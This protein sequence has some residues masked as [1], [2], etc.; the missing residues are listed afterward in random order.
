M[1]ICPLITQSIVIDKK[2][3]LIREADSTDLDG[4]EGETAP[5]GDGEEDGEDSE[6]IS[7]DYE[8]GADGAASP[9]KEESS[10]E[11]P[12]T[13]QDDRMVRF[14]AKSYRGEV[15]C[16]AE[17]CRFYDDDRRTCRLEAI[18]SCDTSSA[19][20]ENEELQSIRMDVE[21]IWEFQQKST[22]EILGLFKELEEKN[23]KLLEGLE[24]TFDDK[25]KSI[26]KDMTAAIEDGRSAVKSVAETI[27]DEIENKISSGEEKIE[28][29]RKE[30]TDW[31][32]VL[33]K[34]FESLESELESHKK[35]VDELSG[36]H[37]EILKLIEVQPAR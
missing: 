12:G 7:L 30:I 27:R 22:S 29:F 5:V 6:V 31:R 15:E 3:L 36:N 9:G 21:K 18:L 25:W 28:F 33:G 14:I 11:S 32:E 8:D 1:K 23:G 10:A 4:A 24:K 37:S 13:Q 26:E 17:L 34:N 16:L 20:E 2:E 35:I 19:E